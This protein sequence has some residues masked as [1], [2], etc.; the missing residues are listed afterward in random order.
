[1]IDRQTPQGATPAI[2]L[3]VLPPSRPSINLS[4]LE[5]M[6]VFAVF[7]T[8]PYD[9]GGGIKTIRP[10]WFLILFHSLDGDMRA[11]PLQTHSTVGSTLGNMLA[12]KFYH[13]EGGYRFA[14]R[15]L[16]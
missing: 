13:R 6:T 5:K 11:S 10:S 2:Q 8:P 7:I 9:G 3:L 16:F 14:E 4:T 15:S 12:S 1:V